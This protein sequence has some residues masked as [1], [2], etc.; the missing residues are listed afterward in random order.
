MGTRAVITVEDHHQEGGIGEAVRSALAGEPT[1]IY[2]L[3]VR[4]IP[5]SGRPEELLDYEEISKNA[6]IKKAR[7]VL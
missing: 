4:K 2:S 7:E 5:R 3:A 6:I 1:P